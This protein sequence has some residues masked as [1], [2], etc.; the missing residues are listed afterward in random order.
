M[1]RSKVRFH[2]SSHI[3]AVSATKEKW[4]ALAEADQPLISNSK[5]KPWCVFTAPV[6]AISA[7]MASWAF[8]NLQAYS[9]AAQTSKQIG[10]AITTRVG[11]SNTCTKLV[12]GA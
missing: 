3:G 1:D 7:T 6:G 2:S 4:K 9:S 8:V 10:C 5:L 11:V 12:H